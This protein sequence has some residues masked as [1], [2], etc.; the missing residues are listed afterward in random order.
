MFQ[1]ACRQKGFVMY[2]TFNNVVG[3]ATGV[4]KDEGDFI[5][6]LQIWGRF[7]PEPTYNDCDN[8]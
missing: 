7:F 8:S 1:I 4:I 3:Q 2:G 6:W 5:K